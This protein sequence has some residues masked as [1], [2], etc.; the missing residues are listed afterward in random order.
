MNIAV[1]LPGLG[2]R[3]I[4]LMGATAMHR[5]TPGLQGIATC[6]NPGLQQASWMLGAHAST[7]RRASYPGS[8]G[9]AYQ[10]DNMGAAG[11]LGHNM[12]VDGSFANPDALWQALSCGT[13]NV[14]PQMMSSIPTQLVRL[15]HV[16]ELA[17]CACNHSVGKFLD[18]RCY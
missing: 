12:T 2:G 5:L 1:A 16:I 18:W 14:I 6:A 4:P 9:A 13:P 10:L 8:V 7:G 11:S 3:A 17:L 15:W